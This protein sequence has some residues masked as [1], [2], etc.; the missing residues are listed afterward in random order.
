MV[1]TTRGA[2]AV[3]VAGFALAVT[4]VHASRFERRWVFSVM[5]RDRRAVTGSGRAATVGP[6]RPC[7]GVWL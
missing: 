6:W 2:L 4:P 5:L 3:E 1:K 7:V